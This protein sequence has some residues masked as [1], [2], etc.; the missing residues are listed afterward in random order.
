MENVSIKLDG[1]FL[2]NIERFMKKYNYM[3]K[4][5]FIR[6]AIR[7]KIQQMEK[8]EMLKE[9]EKMAGSSKRKTTDEQ[10]HEIR[11]KAFEQLEKKFKSKST[12]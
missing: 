10:L 6:Q 12:H 5:E 9:V 2:N 8:E 3:T 1:E 4:A 7:D 11:D